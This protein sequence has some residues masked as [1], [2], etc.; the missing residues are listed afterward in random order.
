VK[1]LGAKSQVATFKEVARALGCDESEE[2]LDA[3]LAKVA[4]HKPPDT[5]KEAKDKKSK[6]AQ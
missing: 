6:P 2:R 4:R 3:A 1:N 5:P